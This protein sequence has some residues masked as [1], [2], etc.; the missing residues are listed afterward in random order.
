MRMRASSGALTWWQPVVA[1]VLTAAGAWANLGK[2]LNILWLQVA[3]G[4]VAAIS[5]TALVVMSWMLLRQRAVDRLRVPVARVSEVDPTEIGVDPAPQTVLA[6]ETLPEYLPRKVDPELREAV[7]EARDGRGSWLVVVRGPSK[8]GKSRTLFEAL[9]ACD[10]QTDPLKLV[11]PING[12]ALQ[13]M[14]DLGEKVL[15]ARQPAVLWLDEL[16]PYLTQGVTW[17]TLRRWRETGRT[18]FVVATYK[19]QVTRQNSGPADELTDLA[20]DLL[21]RARKITL[22]PTTDDELEP[23]REKLSADFE[24]ARQYGLAAYLVAGDRLETRLDTEASP[25]GVAVI[26]A[27]ADW[28]RC[29]RTS[30]ISEDTL[31]HLWPTYLAAGVALSDG[32]FAVGRD[33]AL[34]RVA[35]RIA[36]LQ[37][38]ADGYRAYDY[39]VG[40]ISDRPGAGVPPD[41]VWAAAIETALPTEA[42]AVGAAAASYARWAGAADA[43]TRARE[44]SVDQYAAA[45]GVNLG[46]ALAQINRS[47]D[48]V[49]A[50]QQVI[51]RYRDDAAP[52]LREQVARALTNQGLV[53]SELVR[54]VDA[55]TAYQP[56]EQVVQALAHHGPLLPGL[57][58]SAEA[59]AACQQVINDYGADPAPA[60]RKQ[61]ARALTN[62]GLVLGALIRFADAVAA[63]QQV[64][65]RYGADPA[66]ALREQVA[67]AT[68]PQRHMLAQLD[69]CAD[70]VATYQQ[71]LIDPYRDDPD[72]EL[73]EVVAD[74]LTS[75]SFAL[76]QLGRTAEALAACQ[77]VIDHYGDDP[78]PTLREQV[79]IALTNQGVVLGWLGRP[80]E[81]RA[82]YQRVI[83]RY[84]DD[85]APNLRDLVERATTSLQTSA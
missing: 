9:R 37:Q 25:E 23:L 82:V 28:A 22:T 10:S 64:I 61:V 32:G 66:P 43:F 84:R 4:I 40:L 83:N 14:I 35:G 12:D 13:K 42:F 58:R 31:R 85:P 73:R 49:A 72:P 55:G 15:P 51:D 18:R 63:F 3:G 76:G 56:G 24:T 45:G 26:G 41:P 20:D 67:I 48:A 59:L 7:E 71:R 2:P 8:V 80:A 33:W 39:V 81:A 36:L 44:S 62:Q 16:E 50:Y 30:A 79:A 47:A 68:N 65:D 1:A 21:A 17:Q 77:Q 5:A 11:A 34:D 53:L 19:G 70:A 29:G 54:S 78:A 74:A 57:G 27:A 46:I 69:R 6:G 75:Q 52:A 60:L 38:G